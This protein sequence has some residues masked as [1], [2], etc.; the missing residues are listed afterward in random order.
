MSRN[1][2]SEGVKEVVTEEVA[3]EVHRMNEIF[4]PQEK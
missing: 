1:N 3:F 4:S 2:V